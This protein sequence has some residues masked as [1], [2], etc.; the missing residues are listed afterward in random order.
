VAIHNTHHA[1][2]LFNPFV[3]GE[4]TSDLGHGW[5]FTYLLGAYI[6]DHTKVAYSSS[7]LNQRFGLSYTANEWNLT[8]NVIWGIN[9]DQSTNKPQGF[10][11]PTSPALGCNPNFLNV[12][13]T[14]T[15]RFGKWELGPIGFYATDI[16]TPIVGYQ[17]QSKA[18]IGGLVGY[19][20]GP[21]ILQVY[22]T[23]EFYEKN[24]G[25]K[26]TRIWSR[27]VVPLGSPPPPGFRPPL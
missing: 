12:D 7:S 5:G 17:R 20:F 2:G 13:L 3:G 26:D 14:G 25:G 18:A 1:S 21:F 24:Y 6:D 27:L 22:G 11:C 8:A 4:L 10:P 15:K 23:T 9:F 16:S 19:W